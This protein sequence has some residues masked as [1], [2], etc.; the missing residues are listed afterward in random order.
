[1]KLIYDRLRD[2]FRRPH[3]SLACIEQEQ[4]HV[5]HFSSQ[6]GAKSKVRSLNGYSRYG[7]LKRKNFVENEIHFLIQHKDHLEMQS[8]PIW[9]FKV[10]NGKYVPFVPADL[11]HILLALQLLKARGS[12][13]SLLRGTFKRDA[14]AEALILLQDTD[15]MVKGIES[16]AQELLDPLGFLNQMI[17]SIA[18]RVRFENYGRALYSILASSVTRRAL[19]TRSTSLLH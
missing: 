19:L 17:H 7:W 1:M 16:Y 9:A 18:R 4:L 10:S 8:K 3:I 6:R 15:K 12:I 5:H 14:F 13:E 2:L 11:E